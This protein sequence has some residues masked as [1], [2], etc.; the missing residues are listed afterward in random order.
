MEEGRLRADLFHRIC[1]FRIDLPPLRHRREDI[2]PLAR[3][4]LTKLAA[5]EGREVPEIHPRAM[6]RLQQ[7]DYPGNV[8]EL[9]NLLERAMVLAGGGAIVNDHIVI[10]HSAA[11]S[12]PVVTDGIT[13][14]KGVT[15]ADA[16][17]ILIVE[18]L[19]RVGNNKAEAARRLGLDVK[20]IRNKLKLFEA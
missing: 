10:H 19:K 3:H 16:E 15:A 11:P 12:S 2:P 17:R 1:V 14:P 9:R 5:R 7:H 18:T 4:L 6:R 13:L 20:T 8:R